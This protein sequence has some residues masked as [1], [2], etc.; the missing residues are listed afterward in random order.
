LNTK[1]IVHQKT[2]KIIYE[3]LPGRLGDGDN[4]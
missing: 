3:V 2:L 4:L 1:E